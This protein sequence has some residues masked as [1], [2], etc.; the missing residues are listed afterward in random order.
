[1]IF[2]QLNAGGDRN[3]SYIIADEQ[4]KETAVI[5]PGLPLSEVTRFL[6]EK[7][8]KLKYIINTHDHYDHM[9]GNK[10]LA[11]TTGAKIAMQESAYS[12]HE[13]DLRTAMCSISARFRCVSF[14]R[15]GILAILSVFMPE[16][17][18]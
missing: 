16:M 6:T 3:F 18:S 15:R 4:S 14:I 5:D 9:G 11:D 17:N 1:M 2:K 10:V 12:T 13:I 7:G 8:L